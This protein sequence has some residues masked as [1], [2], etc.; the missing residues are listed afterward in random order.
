MNA[1]QSDALNGRLDYG[2]VLAQAARLLWRGPLLWL[3]GSLAAL[4]ALFPGLVRYLL[5]DPWLAGL[6]RENTPPAAPGR[7]QLFAALGLFILFAL[8]LW[9]LNVLAEASLIHTVER[10]EAGQHLSGRAVL[11]AAGRFLRPLIALDT[12]LFLP[13]LLLTV[14]IL[15]FATAFFVL[16][17]LGIDGNFLDVEQGLTLFGGGTLLCVL[18]LLCLTGL[19]VLLTLL[20]RTLTFRAAVVDQLGARAALRQSW[21]L[22]RGHALP[23]LLVAGML[24]V[25]RSL[26][27]TAGSVFT[28]PLYWLAARPLFSA[29][30]S[31][32][33]P[34]GNPTLALLA[35]LVGTLITFAVAALLHSYAA[36]VWT[37][38]YRGLRPPAGSTEA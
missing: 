20:L 33:L 8:L 35:G 25:L 12:L 31:G 37:L 18:P 21:L 10:L 29:L 24:W 6:I 14:L 30:S 2:E 23:V 17:I 28:L 26:A 16:A 19:I 38:V 1:D 13:L 3:F 11:V 32:E 4:G 36:T 9:L 5:F 27:N 34:G 22:V 15:F 7:P